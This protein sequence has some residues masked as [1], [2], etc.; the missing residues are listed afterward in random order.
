MTTCTC[1]NKKVRESQTVP[2]FEFSSGS[3]QQFLCVQI[4]NEF[5]MVT[6]TTS[7]LSLSLPPFLPQQQGECPADRAELGRSTWVFLHTMAA[8]YPD[9]PTGRQQE[10][11]KQFMTLFSKVYPCEDCAEHMQ[12]RCV[13]VPNGIKYW[14]FI[15]KLK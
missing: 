4:R 10:E 3:D 2:V 7:T 15:Y 8:Y 5:L 12:K 6:L 11:M 1:M 13:H 9:E 14:I